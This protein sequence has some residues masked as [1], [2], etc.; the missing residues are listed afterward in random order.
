MINSGKF[1]DT[2]LIVHTKPIFKE[3][4]FPINKNNHVF[5]NEFSSFNLVF[6]M[7]KKIMERL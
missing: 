6:L 4:K 7:S 5:I 2:D 3:V 1:I